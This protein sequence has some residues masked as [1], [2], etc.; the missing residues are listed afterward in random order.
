M[1]ACLLFTI[2]LNKISIIIFIL[3]LFVNKV[4]SLFKNKVKFSLLLSGNRFDS[5]TISIDKFINNFIGISFLKF[6][7]AD[8]SYIKLIILSF[9][10]KSH[11][12]SSILVKYIRSF[13]L[14]S[15]K[16]LFI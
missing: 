3:C 1:I 11:W 14:I 9:I 5:F 4:D 15:L 8:I 10:Y 13:V 2:K 12:N 7:L 16:L 6:F